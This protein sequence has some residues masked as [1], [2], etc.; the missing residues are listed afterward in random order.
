MKLMLSLQTPRAWQGAAIPV[1]C[2]PFLIGKETGCHL[3]ANSPSVNPR[4]CALVVRDGRVFL[5]NF[6]G[7]QETTVNSQEVEGELEV[8]DRDHVRAGEL[9]FTI[10]LECSQA[11]APAKLA[12]A[13]AAEDDEEAAAA[14]L[15]KLEEEEE[16]A[17]CSQPSAQDT[18]STPG[19]THVGEPGRI[20]PARTRPADPESDTAAAA[21]SL[22]ARLRKPKGPAIGDR[23]T[24]PLH[25]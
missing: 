7:R 17:R 24:V 5:C 18:L 22:L 16:R 4:H 11:R 14:L 25:Q 8:H 1:G 13:P 19:D 2:S 23:Q 12:P 15:L 10:Q 21:R 9:L 20:R 6:A 3:R